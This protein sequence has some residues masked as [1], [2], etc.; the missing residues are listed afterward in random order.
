[1]HVEKKEVYAIQIHPEMRKQAPDIF[2][3]AEEFVFLSRSEA[4]KYAFECENSIDQYFHGNYS[5]KQLRLV[6]NLRE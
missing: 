2:L 1:M 6:S 5:I 4:W 3:D